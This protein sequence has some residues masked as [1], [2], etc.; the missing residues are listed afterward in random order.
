MAVY[1]SVALP[2][3]EDGPGDSAEGPAASAGLFAVFAGQGVSRG[4]GCRDHGGPRSGKEGGTG[5]WDSKVKSKVQ[6]SE[7]A[8]GVRSRRRPSFTS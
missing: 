1:L 8:G 3:G 4:L 5:L 7:V 6:D 2:I